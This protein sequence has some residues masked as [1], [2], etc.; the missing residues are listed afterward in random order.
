[1]IFQDHT[2]SREKSLDTRFQTS[3]LL[4]FPKST[5]APVGGHGLDLRKEQQKNYW[6]T[7]LHHVFVSSTLILYLLQAEK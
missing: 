5:L 1:M 6:G 7:F 4:L 2:F 3:T